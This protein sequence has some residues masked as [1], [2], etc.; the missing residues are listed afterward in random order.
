M[1]RTFPI[2][3][4]AILVCNA[5]G[6]EGIQ[7]SQA[8]KKQFFDLAGYVQNELERRPW[9]GQNI[10]KKISVNGQS[11]SQTLSNPDLSKDLA[12]LANADINK[13]AWIDKYRIETIDNDTTYIAIDNKLRTQLLQVI[14]DDQNA[15]ARIEVTRQSG[16]IL[17]NNNQ[18]LTYKPASGYRISS[19]QIGDL[20]GSTLVT[21]EVEW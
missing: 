7:E 17:S 10:T 9:Q 18:V 15:V 12:L 11:E 1:K 16:N 21:V 3:L 4:L 5:C 6:L 19:D 20:L 14:R 2:I 13:P 8:S